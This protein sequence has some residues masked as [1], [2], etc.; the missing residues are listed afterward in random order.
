MIF[1][2]VTVKVHFYVQKNEHKNPYEVKFD[3]T[4]EIFFVSRYKKSL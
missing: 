1:V 4:F 2:S 3:L